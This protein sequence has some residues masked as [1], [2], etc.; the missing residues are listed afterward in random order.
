MK[1]N[2]E[3]TFIVPLCSI[4]VNWH[5]HYRRRYRCELR[6]VL[7]IRFV[8]Y[9]FGF[10]QGALCIGEDEGNELIIMI[11]DFKQAAVIALIDV[12]QIGAIK[13]AGVVVRVSE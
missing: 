4:I 12:D 11:N 8:L 7:A 5:R 10:N 3:S 2:N 1:E 13:T 9:I 6:Y